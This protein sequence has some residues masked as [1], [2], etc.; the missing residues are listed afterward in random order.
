MDD[1]FP[2]VRVRYVLVAIKSKRL[3]NP[4]PGLGQQAGV[5]LA[6]MVRKPGMDPKE[7]KA[8]G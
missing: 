3:P 8:D 7:S 2:V 6:S 5:G 1:P 4:K